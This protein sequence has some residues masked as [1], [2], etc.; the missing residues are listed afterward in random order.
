M[1]NESKSKIYPLLGLFLSISIIVFTLLRAK[2]FNT[3]Y[4]IGTTYLIFLFTG[5]HKACLK[6]LPIGIILT[7]IFS[8]L[9]YLIY[10]NPTSTYQMANRM[11]GIIVAIIPSMS[12]LPIDLTRNLNQIKVPRKITLGMLI[13]LNFIPMLKI[14][15]KNIKEAMKT[16]G[17]SILNPKIFYRAF[18]IPLI[19]RLVNISDTL[20]LSVEARGFKMEGKS[21][22]YK[23]VK[24]KF[25]DI[26]IFLIT[27]MSAILVVIV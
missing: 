25:K 24:L 15:V 18:L 7:L 21:S 23:P 5:F 22:I 10:K 20:A 13:C 8:G 6:I 4:F 12:I 2:H 19:I 26:F 9:T 17:V 16:R 14:E 3:L 11:L 27:I 1:I